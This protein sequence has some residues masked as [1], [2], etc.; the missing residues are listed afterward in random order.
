MSKLQSAA[1]LPK[2]YLSALASINLQPLWPSLRVLV[3]HGSSAADWRS[4][5]LVTL[6]RQKRL[7]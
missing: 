7:V 4:L 1:D 2:E 5:I 3:S 6:E